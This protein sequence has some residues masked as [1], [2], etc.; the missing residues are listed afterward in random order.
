MKEREI[1]RLKALNGDDTVASIGEP[2]LQNPSTSIQEEEDESSSSSSS[3]SN[4]DS[5]SNDKKNSDKNESN[6]NNQNE[7]KKLK[8]HKEEVDEGELSSITTRK[9]KMERNHYIL[10]LAID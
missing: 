5:K 3:S 10:R 1:K 4:E 2:G 6:A 8:N 7:N 9:S